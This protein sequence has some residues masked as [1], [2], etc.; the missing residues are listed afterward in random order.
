MRL[1]RG[2]ARLARRLLRARFASALSISRQQGL[3]ARI[4]TSWRE[5]LWGQCRVPCDAFN[6]CCKI[7][8]LQLVNRSDC[9]RSVPR[10]FTVNDQSVAHLV[11]QALFQVNL[12]QTPSGGNPLH[13]PPAFHGLQHGDFVGVFDVAAYRD[14]HGNAGYAQSLPLEL[15]G[16]VGGGSFSFDRGIGG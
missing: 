15:L 1:H 16:E 2:P 13:F 6:Y 14:A 12:R 3:G 5:Q 7:K 10:W 4:Q 9:R 11:L 8:K